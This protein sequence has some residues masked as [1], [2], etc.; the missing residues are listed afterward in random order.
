MVAVIDFSGLASSV[1]ALANAEARAA[2]ESLERCMV[3]LPGKEVEADN[4]VI[5]LATEECHRCFQQDEMVF[6]ARRE[7]RNREGEIGI[8]RLT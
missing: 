5:T 6:W 3:E 1:C 7:V 4:D 2:M 8:Y